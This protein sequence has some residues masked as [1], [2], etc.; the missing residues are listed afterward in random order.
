[1]LIVVVLDMIVV[2]EVLGA[3]EGELD[4]GM[5]GEN[6]VCRRDAVKMIIQQ[7]KAKE[8]VVIIYF[9]FSSRRRH[10]RYWRDWSSD[11]C[12]SDLRTCPTA[13]SPASALS[14]ASSNTCETRPRS[15]TV[16]MWPRS[17]EAI[18]ADSW[19]RCCSA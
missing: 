2:S 7:S 1:M 3:R 8:V 12:S 14:L 5:Y 15:R 4:K 10:T 9:F 13:M 19:P 17:A 16:M 11:V 6:V 18:P